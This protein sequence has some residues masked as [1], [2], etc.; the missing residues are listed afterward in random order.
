MKIQSLSIKNFRALAN[1]SLDNLGPAV[2]LAGPNGCGKSCVLDAIR[3]LKSAYGSYQQDEWQQWIGEFQISLNRSLSELLVLFNNKTLS[4]N[5]SAKFVLSDHEKEYIRNNIE[6][7]IEDQYWRKINKGRN[8]DLSDA[9]SRYTPEENN[10]HRKSIKGAVSEKSEKLLS[11]V[12]QQYQEAELTIPPD[13]KIDAKD[14][15]LLELLFSIYDSKNIGVFDFHGAH[16]TYGRERIGAINLTIDSS[17]DRRRQHSLYNYSNKYSNIKTEIASAYTRHLIAKAKNPEIQSE[18]SLTQTLKEL[19][20]TFFPGKEFLGPQPTEDGKL[21][22]HVRLSNGSEHD[23]DEL[24]SGEKEVL[25]GYLRLHSAN[26]RHSIILI[27]EPELH[28][29]PRLLRG[30]AKFYYKHIC[31]RNGNQIWL[32]THS[33]AIIREAI[34]IKHFLVFHIQPIGTVGVSSQATVVRAISELEQLLVSLVGD[35]AAYK[36]EGKIVFFESTNDAAFDKRVT[37]A[38]FPE[39]EEVVNAISGGGKRRVR[40]LYS[41]LRKAAISAGIGH[42][43]Y[44]IT[45]SDNEPEEADEFCLSWDVYHIENYFLESSFIHGAL[46]RINAMLPETDTFQKIEKCL[47]ECAEA[48]VP[49]LIRHELTKQINAKLIRCMDLSR[50]S[51]Q[52]DVLAEITS[53]MKN[54]RDKVVKV[55]NEDY[56]LDVLTGLHESLCRSAKFDL[57]KGEW[58]KKFRGRDILK[59]FVGRFVKTGINYDNFVEL[60]L[61]E[62]KDKKHKPAGMKLVVEKIMTN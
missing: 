19:F 36:P 6:N 9:Q 10:R 24:S 52:S 30:L 46:T 31:E 47:K 57:T 3:L 58:K 56:S 38:L 14:N 60:I 51:S 12:D 42:K 61:S 15:D 55:I 34:A 11:Q 48:T 40:E 41:E 45:D 27:D 39:F 16:R 44:A 21:L 35:L 59:R 33:D 29:N 17:E 5:I 50:G 53:A 62:M 25:Y 1:L 28:L 23:I 49:D 13:G 20:T 18:D 4:V 54:G 7:L 37:F 32:V 8:I 26:L 22:F 43:F 2:V